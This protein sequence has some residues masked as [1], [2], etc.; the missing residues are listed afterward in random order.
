MTGIGGVVVAGVDG[1]ESGREALRAAAHEAA[2]NDALLVALHVRRG[3]LPMEYLAWESQAYSVQWRDELELEAWLHCTV[4]LADMGVDWEYVV[5]DGDPAE[6]IGTCAAA[7]SAGA[8]YVGARIR[9]R[10][11]ARLH[12]CPAVLLERRCPCAVRVVRFPPVAAP[13][14]VV[15]LD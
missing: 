15:E 2:G 14:S 13:G 3:P 6:A 8:V 12:R 7:R 11:A 4:L 10:W 1:T 5:A 9:T